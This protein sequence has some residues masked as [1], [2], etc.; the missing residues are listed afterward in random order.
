[1]SLGQVGLNH[2]YFGGPSFRRRRQEADDSYYLDAPG[3]RSDHAAD[4]YAQRF[5]H[6][7]FHYDVDIRKNLHENLAAKSPAELLQMAQIAAPLL[8]KTPHFDQALLAATPDTAAARRKLT[9]AL[10]DV[11]VQALQDVTLHALTAEQASVAP[12]SVSID[13]YRRYTGIQHDVATFVTDEAKH[14]EIFRRYLKQ[15]L[16][17]P[18]IGNN[19]ANKRFGQF[20]FAA[21]RTNHQVEAAVVLL[22]LS[23][24]T[25]GGS[26][27]EF[28]A[29]KAPDPLFREMCAKIAG[30]DEQRHMAICQYIYNALYR[31]PEGGGLRQEAQRRIEKTRND[32]VFAI[33][34]LGIYKQYTLP[35]FPLVRACR[36][37]GVNPQEL[38]DYI[39]N[40]LAENY[41]K[42]GYYPAADKTKVHL[43]QA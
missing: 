25:I 28:F 17:Q 9:D 8:E 6:T 34:R 4:A 39:G 14:A 36:A 23:V 40:R 31:V 5:S 22:A 12:L 19:E 3:Y 35:D 42:I 1:M 15:T 10:V 16:G 30:I 2:L 11:Q 27:F 41:A 13:K 21:R 20:K 32:T 7:D 33:L 18:M 24:E 29:Q 43:E 26:F 37:F 38:F